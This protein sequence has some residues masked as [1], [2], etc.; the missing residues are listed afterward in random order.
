MGEGGRDNGEGGQMA[1]NGLQV[2]RSAL[3]KHYCLNV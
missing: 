2:H 3:F 1:Q